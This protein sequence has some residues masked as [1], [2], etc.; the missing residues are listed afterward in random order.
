MIEKMKIL[1][2]E[3]LL[4][5]VFAQAAAAASGI[6]VV[7]GD[8]I[9]AGGREIRLSGIDAPEYF[10]TCYDAGGKEYACGKKARRALEKLVGKDLSCKRAARDKYGRDVSVCFS[11]GVNINEKMVEIGWAVAYKRYTDEYN[12]AEKLAKKNKRGIWQGR[13]MKPE[14]YRILNRK[15]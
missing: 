15:P 11:R 2:A 4:L 12:G 6:R 3:V 8:S 14:L 10:Q 9:M 1:C 7:D 13:F 5:S